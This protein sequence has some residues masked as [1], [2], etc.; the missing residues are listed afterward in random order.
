MGILDVRIDI[1]IQRPAGEVFDF[2][3]DQTNAPQWQRGLSAVRRVTTDPVGV[4]T[5]HVFERRFAGMK[6]ESRNRYTR[7]E[8]GRLVSFEIP[9]GKMTGEASYLVEPT[10]TDC[11]RL[12][13]EMHFDVSGPAA[14]AT[15]L[16]AHLLERDGKKNVTALKELLE[17]A[18]V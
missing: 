16:L 13:S 3:A 2:V 9:S 7:Y 4:G 8:P 17:R 12:V 15:P 18:P 5:E 11:C 1:D 14:L 10:G 6:V